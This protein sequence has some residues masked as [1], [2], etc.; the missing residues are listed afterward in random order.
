[1]EKAIF[2]RARW[3]VAR[4][5]ERKGV[6]AFLSS[7]GGNIPCLRL[8]DVAE[9]Q[10]RS[11]SSHTRYFR[12]QRHLRPSY[13]CRAEPRV[14]SRIPC[15]CS[16]RRI[17]FRHSLAQSVHRV[18]IALHARNAKKNSAEKVLPESNIVCVFASN[19]LKDTP[20]FPE[21]SSVIYAVDTS[22]DCMMLNKN[23]TKDSLHGLAVALTFTCFKARDKTRSLRPVSEGCAQ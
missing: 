22:I 17:D 3:R 4:Y 16:C 13:F 15:L 14:N 18:T 20:I 9:A 19:A 6:Q 21:N 5:M 11:Q 1:M 7:M 12:L 2:F 10:S 23:L 8:P